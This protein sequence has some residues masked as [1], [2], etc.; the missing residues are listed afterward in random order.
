VGDG[1]S[2]LDCVWF[3]GHPQALPEGEVIA[4]SGKIEQFGGRLQIVH[5]EIEPLGE[6]ETSTGDAPRM[7]HTGT[8]VPV[9]GSGEELKAAGLS[10]RRWRS[11]VRTALDCFASRIEENISDDIRNSLSLCGLRESLHAVHTPTS[12][13]DAEQGR[14]RLAFDELLG[15]QLELSRRRQVR[16]QGKGFAHASSQVLEPKF[17]ASL[18]FAFTEAQERVRGEILTDMAARCPMRRLLH[19]EVGS[20]KTVVAL[21]AVLTAVENGYQVAVMVPTEVLAEQHFATIQASAEF[22]QLSTVLL[23]GGQASGARTELLTALESGSARIVIGTHALIQSEVRFQRLGLIIVDEQ[24]RFGVSQREALAAKGPHADI[25]VMTATPIPRSLALTLYGDLDISTL[26]QLPAGRR[27]VRTVVRGPAQR[28]QVIEFVA[29]E[30]AQGRQAYFVY[31]M[32]DGSATAGSATAGSLK[33]AASAFDELTAGPLADFDVRFL[34][35]RM[36]SADK[37]AVMGAFSDGECQ[38]LV[39]TSVVEV[40]LDVP[41]A[42]IMVVEDADRFG[43]AQL[44]QLRGRVGRGGEG[45][46]AYCILIADGGTEETAMQRLQV[47][48]ETNDGFRIAQE[49]LELRGPGEL[50]GTR[51]AGMPSFLVAGPLDEDLLMAA[52]EQAKRMTQRVTNA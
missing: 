10:S 13:A 31:P 5:P 52:R 46:Q 11:L 48:S 6:S 21:C 50:Q 25:V 23:V 26:D 38:A 18:P 9:Y 29:Q 28:P 49:D 30:L 24:H 14:R 3:H 42:T 4:I 17:R 41:G 16:L 19:G 20:G 34:H 22:A 15:L 43:L 2:E 51:Q 39:C 40:G 44:H 36:S 35:G 37:A 47:L 33:S 7:I 8:I 27:P 1:S 32:I 12:L 45:I